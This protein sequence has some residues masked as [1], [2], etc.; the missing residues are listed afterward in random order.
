MMHIKQK[1]IERDQDR[2]QI[3]QIL[4][5]VFVDGDSENIQQEY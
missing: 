2:G 3:E 5:Q 1:L 4:S